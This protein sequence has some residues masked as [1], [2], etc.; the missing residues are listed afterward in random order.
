MAYYSFGTRHLEVSSS[1][2]LEPKLVFSCHRPGNANQTTWS[3]T[4][5]CQRQLNQ[6][7]WRTKDPVMFCNEEI[8]VGL[9]HRRGI[10]PPTWSRFLA[11]QLTPSRPQRKTPRR[12]RDLLFYS[13]TQSRSSS[14]PPQHH[15]FQQ[16]STMH[17]LQNSLKSPHLISLIHPQSTA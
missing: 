16:T 9:H 8:Q 13:S 1:L 12:C 3:L 10:P 11:C 7:I 2:T 5:S 14:P 4:C 15:F 6:D 17:C